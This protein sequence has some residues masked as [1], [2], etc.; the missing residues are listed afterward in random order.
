MKI[1][2]RDVDKTFPSA[3]GPIRV[4]Q[5]INL[6]VKEGEFYSI[7]GPS[8]CGKTTILNIAAGLEKVDS[9]GVWMD[10]RKVEGPESERFLIFQEP[11]LFPWLNVIQNVEFGLKV[12]GIPPKERRKIAWEYLVM[13]H[14][15]K[16]RNAYV[17]QLS[18]GMKQRVALAR[19]LA[20]DPEVLLMDEPF[21]A[22]DAQTRDILHGELQGIWEKTKKTII[23]VTHN[24]REAVYLSDRVAVMTALPGRIKGEVRIPLPRPRHKED[25]NLILVADEIMTVLREEVEKVEKEELGSDWTFP[26]AERRRGDRPDLGSGI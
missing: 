18:G 9:G 1:Q 2:I 12:K 8:G 4:L 22:L 10:G 19:A 14:L 25:V 15:T 13:V 17:H 23:F 7:I 6:E 11:A 24:V 16:F 26:E 5:T 20:T 21:S 3:R